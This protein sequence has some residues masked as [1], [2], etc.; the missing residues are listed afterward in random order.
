MFAL[1]LFCSWFCATLVDDEMKD[2]LKLSQAKLYPSELVAIGIS[3]TL[4]C[5]SVY[6][7]M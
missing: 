5:F 7:C 6:R 4:N 2:V 3:F 1:F